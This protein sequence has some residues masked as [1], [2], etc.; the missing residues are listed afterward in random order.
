MNEP[1]LQ[2]RRFKRYLLFLFSG[3][4]GFALYLLCSNVLHYVF[5]VRES[6]AA[7]ASV[8]LAVG[9]TYLLQKYV[10][11]RSSSSSRKAFPKYAGLQLGN[12]ALTAAISGLGAKIALP[13]YVVFVVAGVAGVLVSYLVQ[14]RFIFRYDD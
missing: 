14:S 10:T 7:G 1:S 6:Y 4:A 3:G 2:A 12:A 5:Q 13:G 11:F 8:V 9:P